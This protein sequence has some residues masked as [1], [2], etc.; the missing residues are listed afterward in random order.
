[1]DDGLAYDL[2]WMR[3][4]GNDAKVLMK[5][6]EKRH[7]IRRFTNESV[8][9]KK[10]KAMFRAANLAPSSVKAQP[11]RFIIV[12]DKETFDKIIKNGLTVNGRKYNQWL[13]TAPM[14]IVACLEETPIEVH[15]ARRAKARNPGIIDVSI[16][17]EH[18]ILM[19]TA[20]GLGTCWVTRFNE[21]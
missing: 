13:K 6:M 3:G 5:I 17:L 9:T 14:L 8:D 20:L 15:T 18:L 7:S 4:L 19:A 10:L 2:A 16:S 21:N 12:D 1:M 11:A